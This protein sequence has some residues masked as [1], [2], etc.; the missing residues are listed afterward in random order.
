MGEARDLSYDLSTSS[1]KVAGNGDF[2]AW[3]GQAIR[4]G[5]HG[6]SKFEAESQERGGVLAASRG[7][8]RG[9]REHCK[10]P[11]RGSGQS[12]DLKCMSD[13]LRAQKTRLQN[14]AWFPFL[15]SIQFLVFCQS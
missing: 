10:L 7:P 2:V 11:Q 12:S 9:L 15:D 1:N 5:T 4:G 3:C 14:V 8:A 6:G 13:V